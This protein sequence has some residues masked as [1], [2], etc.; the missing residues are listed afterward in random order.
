[1]CKA[2]AEIKAE[3]L[4]QGQRGIVIN[5]HSTGLTPEQIAEMTLLSLSDVL[6]LL[7]ENKQTGHIPDSAKK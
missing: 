7:G 3:G 4:Q 5:M 1:M 2:I 6:D